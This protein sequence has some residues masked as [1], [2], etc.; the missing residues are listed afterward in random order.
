VFVGQFKMRK[1][2]AAKIE[3]AMDPPI[4]VPTAGLADTDA[5]REP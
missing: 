1:P 2:A 4:G 5:I 3:Y